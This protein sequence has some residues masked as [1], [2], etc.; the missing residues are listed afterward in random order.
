MSLPLDNPKD[1]RWAQNILTDAEGKQWNRRDVVAQLL[2]DAEE[3]ATV[4]FKRLPWSEKMEFYKD[5]VAMFNSRPA[6]EVIPGW[7]FIFVGIADN[8]QVATDF[9]TDSVWKTWDNNQLVKSAC[10]L[11]Y[12]PSLEFW[13]VPLVSKGQALLES[14]IVGIPRS[15]TDPYPIAWPE[16]F[17]NGKNS[18]YWP[19]AILFRRGSATIP[20]R[21]LEE[22]A[23][24]L[25]QFARP[26]AISQHRAISLPAREAKDVFVQYLD[27]VPGLNFVDFSTSISSHSDYSSILWVWQGG[28]TISERPQEWDVF[29][30]TFAVS[31]VISLLPDDNFEADEKT[32]LFAALESRHKICHL[33]TAQDST[34]N[35][36]FDVLWVSATEVNFQGNQRIPFGK[37]FEK[38]AK[39]KVSSQTCCL[40]LV[41]GD[42]LAVTKNS[43][44][45]DFKWNQAVSFLAF[46]FPE[47]QPALSLFQGVYAIFTD[48]FASRYLYP[49]APEL[50]IDDFQKFLCELAHDTPNLKDIVL[51]RLRGKDKATLTAF[52]ATKCRELGI[53]YRCVDTQ[54]H[55]EPH[56]DLMKRYL[57]GTLHLSF[58]TLQQLHKLKPLEYLDKLKQQ[59]V[60]PHS[61]TVTLN[62]LPFTGGTT[63]LLQSLLR[64][65]VDCVCL[66]VN[67]FE[68]SKSEEEL[69]NVIKPFTSK[70]W[71][72]YLGIEGYVSEAHWMN[73]KKSKVNMVLIRYSYPHDRRSLTLPRLLSTSEQAY[74]KELAITEYH[75]APEQCPTI[76]SFLEF[77]VWLELERQ[78]ELS[79]HRSVRGHIVHIFF[80][81]SPS[82]RL[83]LLCA[84]FYTMFA[85]DTLVAG[86]DCESLSTKIS[87]TGHASSWLKRVRL[88]RYVFISRRVAEAVLSLASYSEEAYNRVPSPLPQETY[89]QKAF[90][91][92]TEWA[93]AGTSW[94]T[95]SKAKLDLALT[96]AELLKKDP[97]STTSEGPWRLLF[98]PFKSEICPLYNGDYLGRLEKV[99]FVKRFYAKT[100][101]T[102]EKALLVNA[103]LR[104]D[105]KDEAKQ[106]A[107]QL[108]N[109]LDGVDLNQSYLVRAAHSVGWVLGQV[110]DIDT[111][112]QNCCKLLL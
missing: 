43:K 14:F 88:G 34:A 76:K 24:I 97:L 28:S 49:A 100:T 42:A 72:V 13:N 60:N 23:E 67:L 59:I 109:D 107:I 30:R 99:E 61:G 19:G 80:S 53:D 63:L 4:D 35:V 9:A 22:V 105:F 39:S 62:A 48:D 64:L 38:L 86:V 83:F 73:L 37:T 108:F 77:C 101:H 79:D 112:Q 65:P 55:D 95:N 106:L 68:N 70:G 18:K 96:V 26:D 1:P 45:F 92:A 102:E 21:R 75:K 44:K 85:P 15:P 71:N 16:S 33:K 17:A 58:S 46:A 47:D 56:V 7:A 90:S 51:A 54:S 40:H 3:R 12:F 74:M 50:S 57:S 41:L 5:V 103:L 91:I 31:I 110:G 111:G 94:P 8:L 10:D 11:G 29:L 82:A 104:M 6:H 84:A 89:S 32:P 98:F 27:E 93:K 52:E 78:A 20:A 2:G 87:I 66:Y 69:L 36:D 25:Q 81:L